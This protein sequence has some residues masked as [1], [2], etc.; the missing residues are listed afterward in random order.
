ML[1]P[2]VSEL[3][4]DFQQST[5]KMMAA[6]SKTSETV[7]KSSLNTTAS[8]SGSY[9]GFSATA[10]AAFGKSTSTGEATVGSKVADIKVRSE[11]G[12]N[13]TPLYFDVRF[14]NEEC[15]S[16]MLNA[17]RPQRRSPA[18]VL[19]YPSLVP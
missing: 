16:G 17:L 18:R 8:V 13:N 19:E 14:P 11:P 5:V 6:A 1:C 3:V 7:K 2:P 9:G 4:F 15:T 12:V 10:S